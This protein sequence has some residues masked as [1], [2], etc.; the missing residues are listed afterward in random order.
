[1]KKVLTLLLIALLLTVMCSCDVQKVLDNLSRKTEPIILLD[2]DA[3]YSRGMTM[4][5]K[6]IPFLNVSG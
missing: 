6:D 3:S 4:M 1:M 2:L 5:P